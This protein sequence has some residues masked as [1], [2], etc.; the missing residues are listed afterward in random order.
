MHRL[1][2]SITFWCKH[3]QLTRTSGQTR[4][5]RDC[6]THKTTT[7]GSELLGDI[8]G[9]SSRQ[10]DDLIHGRLVWT[11]WDEILATQDKRRG[12]MAL[13]FMRRFR[14]K[15]R[16]ATLELYLVVF[17]KMQFP[18]EQLLLASLVIWTAIGPYNTVA[19]L[20]SA[21][22][23]FSQK[24]IALLAQSREKTNK[25]VHSYKDHSHC[26]QRQPRQDR[27]PAGDGNI[28]CA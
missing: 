13:C 27:T 10:L 24:S 4:V 9:M 15:T 6:C 20:N 16:C 17:K 28:W 1:I 18:L 19:P 22:H 8:S 3:F 14:T 12:M 21:S 25:K 23:R 5:K 11:R 2:S 7:F 26:D